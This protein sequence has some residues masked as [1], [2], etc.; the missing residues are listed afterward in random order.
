MN[1]TMII[2][3]DAAKDVWW[4]YVFID[5]VHN[6]PELTPDWALPSA[7]EECHPTLD[8]AVERIKAWR[9]VASMLKK[10]NGLTA[11]AGDELIITGPDDDGNYT[12]H[13]FGGRRTVGTWKHAEYIALLEIRAREIGLFSMANKRSV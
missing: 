8:K 4:T 1:N 10:N 11:P 3:W 7:L 13:T 6:D 5:G 12:V 9:R 2:E